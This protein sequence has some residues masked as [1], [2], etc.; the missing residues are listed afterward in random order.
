MADQN[1]LNNVNK[2]P[3]EDRSAGGYGF[4]GPES[5]SSMIDMENKS[6]SI[7]TI[8]PGSGMASAK[9]SIKRIIN[10]TGGYK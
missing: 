10:T 6:K 1:P 7:P 9:E 2:Q 5:D 4:Y 3:M 8:Y